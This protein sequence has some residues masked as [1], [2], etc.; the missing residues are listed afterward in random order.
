MKVQYIRLPDAKKNEKKLLVWKVLKKKIHV[1]E[2]DIKL[3]VY[4]QDHSATVGAVWRSGAR[5]E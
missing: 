3:F 1:L 2:I 4:V 5:A